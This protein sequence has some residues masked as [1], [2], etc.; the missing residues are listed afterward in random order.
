M[1]R[2]LAGEGVPDRHDD[3]EGNVSQRMKGKR[4]K[5]VVTIM[6]LLEIVSLEGADSK[7]MEVLEI[8]RDSWRYFSPMYSTRESK[9]FPITSHIRD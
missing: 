3:G 1:L 9:L 7:K 6:L 2:L 8:H 4:N 5:L